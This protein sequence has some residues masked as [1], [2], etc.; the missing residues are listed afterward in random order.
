MPK[1][2]KLTIIICTLNEE[3]NI[4]YLL[5]V[6]YPGINYYDILIVDGG[7]KDNTQKICAQY[8]DI[9]FVTKFDIGLLFQRIHA[10]DI[11]DTEYFAFVDADDAIDFNDFPKALSYLIENNL[12]GVQF[13]TTSRIMNDNYWQNVWSAY[14]GTIYIKNESINM[15]GRPCISKAEL[16][17]NLILERCPTAVEDTYLHKVLIQKFGKL[18]YMVLPY[19][20]YRVCES[21]SVDNIKK[22][23]RYGEGD[24]SITKTFSSFFNCLYHLFVRVLIFRFFK[25]V[26]SRQIYYS[27]GIFLFGFFRL[28]GFLFNLPKLKFKT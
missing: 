10:I 28:I 25:T 15:L 2:K 16:Y 24:A 22:W 21:S 20:S 4:K 19:F 8:E 23:Y 26:L 9:R 18:K 3:V 7:S 11:I 5:E 6:L 12:D 17:R 14:F 1:E 27:P 13:R